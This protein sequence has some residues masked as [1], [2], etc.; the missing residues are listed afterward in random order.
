MGSLVQ[1]ITAR[2]VFTPRF[3]LPNELTAYGLPD[4]KRQPN[5]LALVD[6][7]SV[8]IDSYCGRVDGYGQ[9]SLVYSTYMER[10]IMQSRNRNVVRLSF[11]PLVV[12]DQTTVNLLTASANY[13]PTN[14]QTGK[15]QTGSTLEFTNYFWTGVQA[16][17][18]VAN[19]V[20]GSTISP[21][22]GASGR[23][24]VTV[25]RSD[26]MIYPDLNYGMNPL[27]IASFFGGPPGW[28]P[29][30]LSMSDF[31]PQTG[32]IWVP[33]GLYLSQYTEIIVVYNAGFHPLY[34]PPQIKH[35]TV[36][37]IRNF[38]SRGGGTSGLRSIST[39]GAA[40]ISFTEDLIDTTIERILMPF[41]NLVAY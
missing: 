1:P 6:A 27:M 36:L 26:Y 29:I 14:P 15:Q 39:A 19:N 28:T 7:A 2:G 12:V 38:L 20:P 33:A 4:Y 9:G 10:L 32:E 24:G 30:Q 16:N 23:Y 21:I 8:L 22:I 41:K 3:V 34:L 40:N 35:A 13:L 5:I 11:K 37:L 31:D 17:T 18:Q 25:R